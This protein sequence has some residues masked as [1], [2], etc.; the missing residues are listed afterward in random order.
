MIHDV[1]S[2]PPVNKLKIK[3]RRLKPGKVIIKRVHLPEL[4]APIFLV[5]DDA[6]SRQWLEANQRKLLALK[7]IG[8]VV[9]VEGLDRLEALREIAPELSLM[10]VPADY[11]ANILHIQH[12]P[13]LIFS[14]HITQQV[15]HVIL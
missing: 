11:L 14:D 5:G 2:E 8:F 12:Y 13:V 3:S 4:D 6:L 1:P 9:N 7:A 15:W 10:P